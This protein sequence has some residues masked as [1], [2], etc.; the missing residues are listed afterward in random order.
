MKQLFYIRTCSLSLSTY[1][2]AK[3]QNFLYT[4]EEILRHLG[5]DYV[6]IILQ[7]THTI[8]SWCSQLLTCVTYLS[9]FFAACCW[10][11]G[12]KGTQA[13]VVFP[14]ESMACEIY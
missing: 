5:N 9:V 4:A 3:A 6:Q 7:H 11:G 14:T 13:K 8:D 12:E 2:F 10:W 1:L